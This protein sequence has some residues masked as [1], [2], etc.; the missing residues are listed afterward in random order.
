[1]CLSSVP[2]CFLI[3]FVNAEVAADSTPGATAEMAL[4]WLMEHVDDHHLFSAQQQVAQQANQQCSLRIAAARA[5]LR[6]THMSAVGGG[7]VASVVSQLRD[8]V[9]GLIS[10]ATSGIGGE[11]RREGRKERSPRKKV[12]R[13]PSR[14]GGGGVEGGTIALAPSIHSSASI[15]GDE[16][17]DDNEEEDEDEDGSAG[18]LAS[19]EEGDG[20]EGGEREREEEEGDGGKQEVGEKGYFAN[21]LVEHALSS[22][23]TCRSCE[24]KIQEGEVR[25]GKPA[26]SARCIVIVYNCSSHARSI[27]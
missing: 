10:G 14:E 16:G 12:R 11:G 15:V 13:V 24:G 26:K 18:E 6:G 2:A 22:R 5:A 4:N 20:R 21:W 23:S 1:M 9:G 25:G 7:G 3:S 17:E 8:F 19:C 27:V